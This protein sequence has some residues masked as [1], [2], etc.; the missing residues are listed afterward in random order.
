MNDPIISGDLYVTTCVL[1]K[2]LGALKTSASGIIAGFDVCQR[3]SNCAK[4]CPGAS[5]QFTEGVAR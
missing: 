4:R 3:F 1:P 5:L 2:V